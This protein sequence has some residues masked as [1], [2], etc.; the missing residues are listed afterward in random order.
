M[1]GSSD[2]S[3]SDISSWLSSVPSP[4][5]TSPSRTHDPAAHTTLV[6][7]KRSIQLHDC[8]SDGML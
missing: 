7:G 5:G 3:D 4:A 6:V 2:D 1:F 8:E